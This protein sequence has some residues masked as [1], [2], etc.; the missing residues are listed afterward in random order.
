MI[1]LLLKIS[2]RI[3]SSM[4]C[5]YSGETIS[6]RDSSTLKVLAEYIHSSDGIVIQMIPCMLVS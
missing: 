3:G 2:S 4:D 5:I 6:G 1:Q